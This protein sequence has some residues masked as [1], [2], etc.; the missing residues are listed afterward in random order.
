MFKRGCLAVFTALLGLAGQG[1]A[2]TCTPISAMLC[3]GVDDYADVWINGQCVD[4]VCVDSF[5]YVDGSS[6]SPIKCVAIDPGILNPSGNYIAVKVRNTAPTEM[7][8]TWALD[9]VCAGGFH[10]YSTSSDSFEFYHDPDGT[11]PPP[12]QSGLPWTD[13]AYLPSPPWGAPTTVSGSVYGKRAVDPQSGLLLPPRSWNSS[14]SGTGGN[15]MYFR[16]GFGLTPAPTPVP[17][18]LSLTVIQPTCNA[19]SGAQITVTLRVCNTGGNLTN[20]ASIALSH[21]SE[22]QFSGPYSP[23]GYSISDAGGVATLSLPGV[24]GGG[25]TDFPVYLTNYYVGP[26]EVGNVRALSAA[27]TWSGGTDS[28]AASI[29]AGPSCVYLSPTVTR[30]FTPTPTQAA[31]TATVTVSPTPAPPTATPTASPSFTRTPSS[32]HSPTLS[33]S[34]TP[35]PSPSAT[36]TATVTLPPT[37]APTA[38]QTPVPLLLTPKHPNPSP[39]K[40]AVWIPYVISTAAEVDIRVFDVS[41]EKVLDLGPLFQSAGPH[42]R[43]WDLA[44]AQGRFVASGIYLC[45][46]VA[47]APNGDNDDAWVKVAVAR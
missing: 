39:A 42:E 23:S 12:P 40:D 45:R 7:W 9:I 13:P 22:E 18:A 46:I 35:P 31:D 34:L 5:P 38:T 14:G 16:Q 17:P 8:G 6:G 29:V 10:A 19:D 37:P 3:V 41:G 47:T 11:N 43:R 44:N 33:P 30:S 21:G 2:V 4:T 15:V 24:A 20:T 32:S 26:A 36:A 1:R 28:G 27:L 25:C